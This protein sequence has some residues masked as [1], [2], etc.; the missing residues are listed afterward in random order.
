MSSDKKPRHYAA[1]IAALPAV[2]QR[3]A[4]LDKVPAEWRALVR[5]HVEV[6]FMLRGSAHKRGN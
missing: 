5:R 1:E 3:R 4:A 6:V 2:R